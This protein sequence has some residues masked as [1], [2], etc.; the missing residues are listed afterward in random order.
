MLLFV[1]KSVNDKSRQA[2][3]PMRKR[4]VSKLYN[5]ENKTNSQVHYAQ[6]DEL[7]FL[8]N[9]D[10]MAVIEWLNHYLDHMESKLN[11]KTFELEMMVFKRFIKFVGSELEIREMTTLVA[12]EYLNRET[13]CRN[14]SAANKDLSILNLAWKWGVRHRGLPRENPFE[15]TGKCPMIESQGHAT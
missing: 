10:S 3:E 8:I 12:I 2:M 6:L 11:A 9:K 15:P 5:K 1:V 7:F 14:I 4:T 13:K